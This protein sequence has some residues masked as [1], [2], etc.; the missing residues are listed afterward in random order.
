MFGLQMEVI[1]MLISTVGGAY[2]RMR[3]D[4]QKDLADERLARA[5]MVQSARDFKGPQVSWMRKF[6]TMS[7]IGMAFIILL[8]PM[9]NLPTVV[10]VEVTT[11]ILFWK[12]TV[13]EYVTL[14]GMVTPEY[15]PFTIM[16][17]V[18]FY[19]GNSMAKR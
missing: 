10:P 3:T 7:F 2:I 4:G 5:G 12:E 8:A 6:I 16:S 17:I 14:E 15:L 18:G 9:F 11:G 19:F 13:T 1:T